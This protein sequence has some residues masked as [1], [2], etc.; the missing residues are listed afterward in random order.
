MFVRF[1]YPA[2]MYIYGNNLEEVNPQVNFSYKSLSCKMFFEGKDPSDASKELSQ[3]KLK[4][5]REVENMIIEIKENDINKKLESLIKIDNRK[6][7][8][9]LLIH[10][11]NR[12]IRS[13]R[14]YGWAYNLHEFE[15]SDFKENI[16]FQ[17]LELNIEITYNEKKWDRLIS[18]YD[19]A[20]YFAYLQ[21]SGFQKQYSHLF[22]ENWD[23]IKE[24][25]QDN[26]DLLEGNLPRE[27]EFLISAREYLNNNNFRLALIESVIGLEIALTKYIQ[28]YFIIEKKYTK[29]K[30]N[31]FLNNNF[32]L[33]TR[34][35]VIPILT[36]D[37]I[38]LKE[39]KFD[40]VSNG[41]NWRNKIVHEG[42]DVLGKIPDIHKQ[43]VVEEIINL[44]R[45]LDL[46]V[47]QMKSNPK[48]LEISNEMLSKYSTHVSIREVRY[49]KFQVLFFGLYS[50][51]GSWSIEKIE[52]IN[53]Y[54]I[55]LLKSHDNK[56]IPEKHL[57][58]KY[59]DMKNERLWATWNKGSFI[60][61]KQMK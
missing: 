42:K 47:I 36:L 10:I 54:L 46:K 43:S 1:K 22:Y 29:N 51:N 17:L 7:L 48:M 30:T 20:E 59:I 56:F 33:N 50:T 23:I 9:N 60:Y 34:L 49:H 18:D 15:P 55:M 14:L 40:E 12:C 57:T 27:T 45:L 25:I 19:F 4:Y 44:S 24:A 11:L 41:I 35:S 52:E 26:S 3:F 2:K 37:E 16:D 31:K 13:I 39:I 53:K 61:L 21:T 5:F 58:V 38:S 8:L 28:N 6:E 32:D